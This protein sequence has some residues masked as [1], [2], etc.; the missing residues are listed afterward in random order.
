MTGLGSG[1][2][3]A[4]DELA[5]DEGGAD[6]G[7]FELFGGELEEVARNH[8]EVGALA[9]LEGAEEIELAHGEGGVAGIG[10]E[11]GEAG[12]GLA[13]VQDA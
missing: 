9:G 12:H 4:V 7:V 8:D 10:V 1:R 5:V 3:A 13:G 11:H 2:E 6:L